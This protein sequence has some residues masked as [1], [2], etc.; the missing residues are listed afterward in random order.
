M[1]TRASS[2][3]CAARPERATATALFAASRSA[4]AW[5]TRS[6]KVAGSMR[7]MTWPSFTGELKST[8]IS[9]T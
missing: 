3:C 8:W 6:S 4:R 7:A 9:F 5:F 1:R 2:D